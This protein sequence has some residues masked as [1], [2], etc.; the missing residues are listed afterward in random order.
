MSFLIPSVLEDDFSKLFGLPTF[1]SKKKWLWLL[2]TNCTSSLVD[3]ILAYISK[4]AATGSCGQK[5]S[6][7]REKSRG[8]LS[9]TLPFLWTW[10]WRCCVWVCERN[11]W[12]CLCTVMV[13][14]TLATMYWLLP[15]DM[16]PLQKRTQLTKSRREG[17][18]LVTA[19][20]FVC[21]KCH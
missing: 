11:M 17:M 8:F 16:V 21:K 19:Q 4:L 5:R 9:T 20:S 12:P 1:Q 10:W 14:G 6:I 13:G 7:R 2:T 3:F 18:F 15:Q